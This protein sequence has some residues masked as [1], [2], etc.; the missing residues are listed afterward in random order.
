MID[1]VVVGLITGGAY[2]T[3]ALSVVTVYRIIGVLNLAL[4]ALGTAGLFVTLELAAGIPY[5]LASVLGS[6]VAAALSAAYGLIDAVWFSKLGVVV[7]SS[8]T[9]GLLMGTITVGLRVFGT[10]VRNVPAL[11]GGS[12]TIGDVRVSTTVW[13]S[14]GS[15]AALAGSLTLFLRR[16]RTGVRLRA[17]AERPTTAQLLGIP[18]VRMTML[19]WG[20]TGFMASIAIILLAPT[21]PVAFTELSLLIAP[22]V[23][24]A[25]VGRL[26]DLNAA[27][28]GGIALG[29]CQS[30]M[31]EFDAVQLYQDTLP[32]VV[33]ILVLSWSK[34]REV[35]NDGR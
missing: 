1:A 9:I 32:F 17:L 16:T 29:V 22:A 15:A 34:R 6:V 23:A 13:L 33:I 14:I 11:I 35:W 18:V 26:T 19:A 8:A 12:V 31:N 24:A 21:F 20:V 5:G 28:L 3:L 25:V 7:R 27:V 2:A 10:D 30:L 4:A